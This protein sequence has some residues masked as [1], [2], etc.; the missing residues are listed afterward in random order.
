MATSEKEP[1]EERW[2]FLSPDKHECG[3]H[4]NKT[5]SNFPFGEYDPAGFVCLVP[6]P[7]LWGESPIIVMDDEVMAISMMHLNFRS[8]LYLCIFSSWPT[9]F[10]PQAVLIHFDIYLLF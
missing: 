6:G 10:L 5:R 2:N 9:G 7:A 8:E 1:W 3:W 4:Q